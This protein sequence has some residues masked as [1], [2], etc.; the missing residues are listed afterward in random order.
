M[1]YEEERKTAIRDGFLEMLGKELLDASLEEDVR[2]Q[3]L[4]EY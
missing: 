2:E 3:S 4:G 1:G